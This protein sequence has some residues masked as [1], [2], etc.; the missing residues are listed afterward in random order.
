MKNIWSLPD[1]LFCSLNGLRSLNISSN[2]LQDVN[3]LGVREK[4]QV[5]DESGNSTTVSC[6]LD[7][8]DLDVSQN[9]FV[10]LPGSGFGMLKRLKLLKI[11]DKE[12]SV[13]VDKALNGLKELKL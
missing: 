13:V 10:L 7:L 11:H 9:D 2:W 4:P 12:I 8:E 5:K 3:D 6:N 1:H